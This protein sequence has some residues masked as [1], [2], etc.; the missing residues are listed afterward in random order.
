LKNLDHD[1]LVVDFNPDSIALLEQEDIPHRF[2]DAADAEFLE[3][4][5]LRKPKIAISTVPD[6]DTNLLIVGHMLTKNKHAVII[7]LAQ[8]TEDAKRL[9]DAGATYVLMPHY[10]GAEHMARIIRKNG[11]N[12]TV[13]QPLRERHLAQL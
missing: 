1:F 4:L 10:L 2:G 9:Y 5:P 8:T 3:E 11:D 13:Y 6:L 7:P 12:T